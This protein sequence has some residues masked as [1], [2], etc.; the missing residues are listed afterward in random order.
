M[1]ER[2]RECVE[3]CIAIMCSN[4]FSIEKFPMMGT[5]QRETSISMRDKL[6]LHHFRHTINKPHSLRLYVE[7]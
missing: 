6:E 7:R 2:R 3:M 4:K 1:E 5:V